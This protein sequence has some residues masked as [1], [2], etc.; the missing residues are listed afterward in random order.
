MYESI[1][2]WREARREERMKIFAAGII[3]VAGCILFAMHRNVTAPANATRAKVASSALAPEID[4]KDENGKTV[5]LSDF[6][7][8]VVLL[9]FW[10]TECGACK[11]EIPWFVDLTEKYRGRNFA[12]VG[13]SLDVMYEDLRGPEEGWNLVKP[14]VREK[15]IN[16][17]IL[18]GTEQSADLYHVEAMPLT[19]LID[20]SGKIA[21]AHVGLPD[22]GKNEFQ[23]E[24]DRLL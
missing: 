7:G 1:E 24:I 23:K 11:I 20:Q 9:D 19:L 4:L 6:R 21:F 5:R 14:F 2:T 16:Y 17:P 18:M 22:G 8:K 12:A 3:V 15:R 10:A 13:I